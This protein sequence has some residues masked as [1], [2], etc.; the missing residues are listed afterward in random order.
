MQHTPL[1]LALRVWGWAHRPP[2]LSEVCD[3]GSRGHAALQRSPELRAH[4]LHW[5][6]LCPT[7][8]THTQHS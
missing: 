7:P 4:G 6:G 3:W 2:R 5:Q 8:L 1:C